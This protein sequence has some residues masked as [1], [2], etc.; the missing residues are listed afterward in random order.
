MTGCLTVV[1]RFTES[2][3]RTGVSQSY[4]KGRTYLGRCK[5][6]AD[7]L[8]CASKTERVRHAVHPF[9]EWVASRSGP[10]GTGALKCRLAD[11]VLTERTLYEHTICQYLRTA[12]QKPSP[13]ATYCKVKD[14]NVRRLQ[15]CHQ[16]SNASASRLQA[17]PSLIGQRQELPF[18]P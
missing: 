1:Q 3:V 16:L 5:G 4:R 9:S 13:I 10:R 6:M 15:T 7:G 17:A 2:V 11:T 8:S 14:R 12:V 18:E